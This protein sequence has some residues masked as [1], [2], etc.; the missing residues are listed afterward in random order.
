MAKLFIS[1]LLIMLFS[2]LF[3][4]C[5]GQTIISTITKTQ[6]QT[7]TRTET[8][9][10]TQSTTTIQTEILTEIESQTTTQTETQTET[11][12]ERQTETVIITST[13]IITTTEFKTVYTSNSPTPT[14]TT[15]TTNT[16]PDGEEANF[17]LS[18][19]TISPRIPA[20]GAAF[21]ISVTVTNTDDS[22]GTYEAILYVDEL[23]L[24]DPEN[25]IIVSTRTFSKEVIIPA[26]EV[27]KVIFDGLILQ[28]GFYT[29]TV[30]DLV[31]YFE[32]GS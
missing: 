31:D 18:D 16:P 1:L 3:V 17:S 23:N 12:I 26:G 5:D 19:L 8:I 15:V 25:V 28:G 22:Q 10:E 2:T 30:G 27:K 9:T 24:Q 32:V 20:V 29:A 7:E 21:T 4:A 6:N 11:Q 13:E 14:T